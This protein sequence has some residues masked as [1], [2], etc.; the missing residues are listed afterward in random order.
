MNDKINFV[1]LFFSFYCFQNVS[2][3]KLVMDIICRRCLIDK[4]LNLR[5]MD[6]HMAN[7]K[8][9]KVTTNI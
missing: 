2:K 5:T 1:T 7:D 4:T 9:L 8:S 3:A 6:Y